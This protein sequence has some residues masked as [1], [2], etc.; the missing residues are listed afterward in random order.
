[1]WLGS[2]AA[3]RTARVTFRWRVKP[4]RTPTAGIYNLRRLTTRSSEAKPARTVC[5]QIAWLQ[6]P[7]LTSPD[8]I[9]ALG[10]INGADVFIVVN[11]P[12]LRLGL[13]PIFSLPTDT[14][15]LAGTGEWELGPAG[16]VVYSGLKG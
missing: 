12:G 13:G 5:I 6:V 3:A 8:N 2:R 9:A 16:L 4:E 15:H 11:K 14:Y 1:M 7:V 10:D